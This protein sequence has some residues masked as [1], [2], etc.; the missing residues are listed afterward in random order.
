VLRHEDA[1]GALV[2]LWPAP[3]GGEVYAVELRPGEPRGHHLH[4]RGGEVFVPL[5]GECVVGLLD[6]ESGECRHLRL[7]GE[8]LRVEPGVAHALWAV[9]PGPCWVVAIADVAHEHELTERV[10]V[11]AP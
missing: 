1:R 2:K 7:A 9:G 11:P 8:R 5:I 6:P 3:V 4:R 10:Q